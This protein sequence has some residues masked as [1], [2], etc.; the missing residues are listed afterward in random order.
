MKRSSR[1]RAVCCLAL[2]MAMLFSSGFA[3]GAARQKTAPSIAEARVGDTVLFGSY[4]QDNKDRNGPEP[5]EW[6]VLEKDGDEV[7]LL[8]K[9]CL[10]SLEYHYTG[11]NPITWEESD[12]RVWLNEVF[13]EDAFTDEEREIILENQTANGRKQNYGRRELDTE[14][15]VFLLSLNEAKTLLT[16]KTLSAAEPTEYALARG[17]QRSPSNHH[18]WWW[19][20]TPTPSAG[21]QL[22]MF[23]S[24]VISRDNE[25]MHVTNANGGVRPAIRVVI[26]G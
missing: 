16:K 10:D 19:L 21:Y 3:F 14:D 2:A 7:L 5:I 20:R 25:G 8:S 13:Y 15:Y 22:V 24:G 4:E 23:T 18:S 11:R 9:Y 12:L 6:I 26:G 17:V 1:F